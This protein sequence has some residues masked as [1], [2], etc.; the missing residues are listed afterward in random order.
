MITVTQK[1]VFFAAWLRN[2]V[3]PRMIAKRQCL[4]FFSINNKIHICSERG[5]ST[6]SLF[7]HFNDK[8]VQNDPNPVSRRVDGK[9]SEQPAKSS[10]DSRDAVQILHEPRSVFP[11]PSHVNTDWVKHWKHSPRETVPN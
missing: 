3:T 1:N 11:V 2:I 4:F 5:A 7:W 9:R 10:A 8:G 6:F